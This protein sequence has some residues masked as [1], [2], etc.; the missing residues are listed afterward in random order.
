MP[1]NYSD[2]PHHSR[3]SRPTSQR[4]PAFEAGV[5]SEPL[6][7][8]GGRHEHV[9]PKT[10]LALY[11]PYTLAGQEH[12]PLSAIRVGIVGPAP[13][14]ADAEQWV[15][16]CQG[17]L[18]NDGHQPFLY[19]HFPGCNANHPFRCELLLSETWHETIRQG[20]IDAA[21]AVVDFH[22]RIKR[23]VRLYIQAIEILSQRDPRPEVVLCCIP[24][25]I[26]DY[27]TVRRTKG[28][29]EKRIK[30]SLRERD[31]ARVKWASQLS[32]FSDEDGEDGADGDSEHHNLRRG[33]KA[34][35]M[36]F[37]LPTQIVWPRTL[38]IAGEA[39]AATGKPVQDTATRAWNFITALYHKAGG[40][41][42]RLADMSSDACYVGVSFYRELGTSDMRMRTSM[43][44]AFTASGDGY[45]LRGTPF[46]WDEQQGRSPHLDRPS[47]AALLRGVLDLYQRQNKGSLPNRVVVHKTSRFWE[48]EVDGFND[49]CHLVPQRD[50]VAFGRR[51]L[52]F[53]RTGDYPPLR[54]TYIKLSDTNLL[55]YS[56]GY[57]PYLH[58]YPGP[59]APMPLEILEHHGDSPW[60]VVLQE[61]L[62]LTKMN[63]NTA[64]FALREPITIAFSQRVGQILAE[65]PERLPLRAE[66]RYYM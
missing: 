47:A 39:G 65:L 25:P 49:A 5:L 63:W 2:H 32:L 54:G 12:P 20:E 10:G 30:V 66:Y 41:P 4:G 36:Q 61:V 43:A 18:T 8:F 45:V 52:Q 31:A 15:R 28:G 29:E 55:L 38:Q 56:S 53:Y 58:T 48:E 62:A 23:V 21:L 11:G 19:P 27:C 46:E 35:A 42:W 40:S 64:D 44:Q 60:S 22:E 14:I 13:M 1:T 16:A 34:E 33:L 7:R 17:M 37:N 6:L 26:I 50:Y 9:D 57:V 51:G 3:F 24:Q 59:R